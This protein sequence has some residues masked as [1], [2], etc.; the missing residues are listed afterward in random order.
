MVPNTV[1]TLVDIGC[2][3]RDRMALLMA[4]LPG[5]NKQVAFP[6][7]ADGAKNIILRQYSGHFLPGGECISFASLK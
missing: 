4:T 6:V 5:T 7:V 1:F 2:T 3:S